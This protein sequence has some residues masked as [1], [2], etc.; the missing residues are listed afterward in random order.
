MSMILKLN[1]IIEY[2][3]IIK[4][5]YAIC[6]SNVCLFFIRILLQPVSHVGPVYPG[7]QPKQNPSTTS[8][9]PSKQF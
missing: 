9:R 5:G 7:T 8:H 1:K 2:K 3:I 6:I 4:N